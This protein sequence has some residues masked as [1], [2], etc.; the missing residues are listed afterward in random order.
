MLSC[1]LTVNQHYAGT[2][3][4]DE[5]IL[6]YKDESHLEFTCTEDEETWVEWSEVQADMLDLGWNA[7]QQWIDK[8]TRPSGA[9]TRPPILIPLSTVMDSSLIPRSTRMQESKTWEEFWERLQEP[10][11]GWSLDSG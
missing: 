10:G 7:I 5:E 2:S 6:L 11:G 8:M 1:Q 4:L 9:D 3:S